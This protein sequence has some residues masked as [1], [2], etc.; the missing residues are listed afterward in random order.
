M[1]KCIRCALSCTPGYNSQL[2][3]S[4][5]KV[6][7][8]SCRFIHAVSTMCPKI[9]ACEAV[10]R[11]ERTNATGNLRKDFIFPFTSTKMSEV[12]RIENKYRIERFF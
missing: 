3:L 8:C 6:P 9:I 5:E 4:V 12:M 11:K 10:L 7:Q 2:S 1:Y